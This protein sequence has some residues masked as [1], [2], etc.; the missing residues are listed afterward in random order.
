MGYG[1]TSW[2]GAGRVRP[3]L[4]I[5]IDT[6]K[7]RFDS[8]YEE[9]EGNKTG[10]DDHIAVIVNGKYYETPLAGPVSARL[11]GKNIED[12]RVHT[13]K[14]AW[15]GSP[16]N[17]L[18]VYFDGEL[19]LELTK[20]IKYEMLSG[21]K[22]WWGW[23]GATRRNAF[24][25]QW[26]K[27]IIRLD[28]CKPCEICMRWYEIPPADE[29]LTNLGDYPPVQKYT[30]EGLREEYVN[31]ETDYYLSHCLEGKLAEIR[32]SYE[33]QCLKNI[34]DQFK[35][36]Y[37]LGYHH[38]TLYYYD[39]AGNL[40]KTV[41]PEGIN[42]LSPK[43][44]TLATTYA[45]NSLKQLMSQTTPDS[46]VT[47]FWY[48]VL[49]QQVLIQDAAQAASANYSYIK[50][51]KL[52]RVIETGELGNF[53]PTFDDTEQQI[54]RELWDN[55][56][57]P[58]GIAPAPTPPLKRRGITYTVY[59]LPASD[60]VYPGRKQAH[61]RNR[62]SHSW[63]DEDG[64]P[65]TTHDQYHT[66]YSYD[67][68]GSVEWLV[69]EMPEIGRKTVRYEYELVSGNINKVI[70]QENTQE[71]FIHRYEYDEDNRI[72]EVYTSKDGIVWDKD[73]RY[74]YYLHGPLARVEIGE[75]KIQ[76]IDYIYTIEGYL[77]SINQVQLLP[78]SDPGRDGQSVDGFLKDEFGMELGY[79]HGD[80]TRTGTKIGSDN[81]TAP[82]GPSN[83][84]L[85]NG[86]ITSWATNL[87]SG[88]A[89]TAGNPLGLKMNLYRY[90]RLNRLKNVDFRRFDASTSAWSNPG[91]MYD[92]NFT[93]DAN[94]NIL[95]VNR[96]GWSGYGQSSDQKMDSL[97]YHINTPTNNRL[98]Y[99]DDS[100]G[101]VNAS[102]P[103]TSDLPDQSPDNYQYDAEGKLISD[104]SEGLS[105][106]WNALDKVA[107]VTNS[108]TKE[109]IGYGYNSLGH[110]V[111]KKV[112]DVNNNEEKNTTF[113]IRDVKGNILAIY[114][115]QKEDVEAPRGST[116]RQ[117]VYRLSELPIYGS[118]RVGVYRPDLKVN[119][120]P[121]IGSQSVTGTTGMTVLD[122]LRQSKEYDIHSE[123]QH[124]TIST[125][126]ATNRKSGARMLVSYG[127]ASV[128]DSEATGKLSE[129][130][131]YMGKNIAVAEDEDQQK[132]LDF[133]VTNKSEDPVQVN[134]L[135][136]EYF[137]ND[138]LIGVP[139]IIQL[140]DGI[141]F[142]WGTASPMP[143]ILT[144]DNFSIRWSGGI[145]VSATG[146]YDF[147]IKSDSRVRLFINNAAVIDNWNESTNVRDVIG[148]IHLTRRVHPIKVEFSD[149]SNEASIQL[150]WRKIE[151]YK[152][153]SAAII[154]DRLYNC[155]SVSNPEKCVVGR[156]N[157]G[158]ADYYRLLMEGA[159]CQRGEIDGNNISVTEMARGC[160]CGPLFL[161]P[162]LHAFK[163][164]FQRDS[165]P[166][167]FFWDGGV[168][169]Q[170]SV[171]QRNVLSHTDPDVSWLLNAKGEVIDQYHEIRGNR[172]QS[173][174]IVK[175]PGANSEKYFLITGTEGKLYHH[176][177]HAN[178]ESAI[179]TA[180]Y[181]SLTLTTGQ[182]LEYGDVATP[183]ALAAYND[184]YHADRDLLYVVMN[185]GD[186]IKLYAFKIQANSISHGTIVSTLTNTVPCTG[187]MDIGEMQISPK[188][189]SLSFTYTGFDGSAYTHNLAIYNFATSSV[190]PIALATEENPGAGQGTSLKL[191]NR[192]ISF[193]YSPG[194]K[195]IYYLRQNC[196]DLNNVSACYSAAQK[197]VKLMRVDLECTPVTIEKVMDINLER[198][199]ASVR[200]GA[201]GRLYLNYVSS[202]NPTQ[203]VLQ[204]FGKLDDTNIG[205]VINSQN[206]AALE[207]GKNRFGLPLQS[208]RINSE[209]REA[210]NSLTAERRVGLKLYEIN[211]HLKNVRAVLSDERN[212]TISGGIIT[213]AEPG[214]KNWADFYAYGAIPPGRSYNFGDYTFGFDSYEI[215]DEIE[216]LGN[217]YYTGDRLYD[218]RMARWWGTDPK[219]LFSWSPY[220][221]MN[222]N[223]IKFIDPD[224]SSPRKTCPSQ[225]PYLDLEFRG[226]D[227]RFY[228]ND[229]TDV[230]KELIIRGMHRMAE[231]SE[232]Y[233]L[234]ATLSSVFTQYTFEKVQHL[235]GKK[236]AE[237]VK[238][239]W[240]ERTL[241][242]IPFLF[243]S[244]F[245][246]I[247]E[248]TFSKVKYYEGRLNRLGLE[249]LERDIEADFMAFVLFHEFRHALIAIENKGYKTDQERQAD[250]LLDALR[251]ES[252]L[253]F[254]KQLRFIRHD[255]VED[256]N[257]KERSGSYDL[258]DAVK[259]EIKRKQRERERESKGKRK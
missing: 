146:D 47:K 114:K 219:Q 21:E 137:D 100:I 69:Q 244:I 172:D 116:N 89:T 257:T 123:L 222:A 85:Y 150:K 160:M 159:K 56:N 152:I 66:Y 78:E 247:P 207:K 180:K 211:D 27:P 194:G 155:G 132:V 25:K 195:Y 6:L 234:L 253:N 37:T 190:S 88:N 28:P 55:I 245:T 62:I 246:K 102:T 187:C 45:Y 224:G 103:D 81:P 36:S 101:L 256:P 95:T 19:R 209:C 204:V 64:D 162:G 165:Y 206:L 243:G 143:N 74:S 212:T 153:P 201:D 181:N 73:V 129:N 8:N 122:C 48:N 138:D 98:I 141:N 182:I 110:R 99:I 124:W 136:G 258:S 9:R 15:S 80:Y 144:R 225:Y 135:L 248:N 2:V 228:K 7:D 218:P 42:F 213:S 105:I 5:E 230:Q 185:H 242:D 170:S 229:F 139:K 252:E 161:S 239:G 79:Y 119:I 157:V 217:S 175:A 215:N 148:S 142:S 259:K 118:S 198:F 52:G 223:P 77:K 14:I 173:S 40:I 41:P 38:Y 50:Y 174:I 106:T 202:S 216:G 75:D 250:D 51:D 200:R 251:D 26:V 58:E 120:S 54:I 147:V 93:Y 10:L 11:D 205:E 255:I 221:S 53:N 59:S 111:I 232:G 254:I 67:P 241:F 240:F 63:R 29:I 91:N 126:P 83:Q 16:V 90:D 43:D 183:Y 87:R 199:Q 133:F 13:F 171:V 237:T 107:E 130:D 113:Y 145:N 3:S 169:T 220:S 193:D 60:G 68:H 214:V 92:E 72:T 108:K 140:D 33:G 104:V 163:F 12:D 46:G 96:Y 57:F 151:W 179:L 24:N 177:I 167:A 203:S 236:F 39:R 192:I 23:T 70:F 231:Y 196:L 112:T 233:K 86:N 49:G 226:T 128:L 22:V 31:N 227:T 188:G 121:S 238:S 115:K 82:Y 164:R 210:D 178:P 97:T 166:T 184:L 76:G 30:C 44:H 127:Q 235:E 84:D 208:Y 191:G 94:G 131:L 154:I 32:T 1:S 65:T 189:N 117:Y 17:T 61:L 134:G 35:I 20:D 18:K 34:T 197:A 71:Q 249:H 168:L 158:N 176:A 186:S 109:K 149:L 156:L 4:A 125:G